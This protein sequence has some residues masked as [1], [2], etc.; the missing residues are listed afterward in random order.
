MTVHV[1][2]EPSAQEL[3]HPLNRLNEAIDHLKEEHA[4]LQEALREVYE[5]AC[6]IRQEE[7]LL[8]LNYKLRTLRFTVM[9]FKKALREHS[10]WEETE[11]FPMAA[12]YFGNDM[13]VFTIMEHEHDQAEQRID[14]FLRLANEKPIPVGHADAMQMASQL[15][16]AYAVL[17]NHFKEEEEILVAFADRS[18]SFGY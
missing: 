10:K 14:A 7:D 5:K 17:K 2:Y 16:Q 13:E 11:L 12:W 4:L 1:P 3:N 18:N 6:A 8:L 9:E 15:F